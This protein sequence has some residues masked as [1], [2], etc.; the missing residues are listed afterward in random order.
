V[1]SKPLL[2][3]HRGCRVSSLTR[4]NSDLPVENSLAAFEYALSQG[5]DGFEFDV[6]QTHDSRNVIW[7]DDYW[8]GLPIASTDYPSLCGPNG[9]LLSTLDD[10]LQQ[11]GHRAFLDIELKVRGVEISVVEALRAVPPQRGYMLSSFLPD[12]LIRLHNIDSSLPFGYICERDYALA[13]WRNI[14]IQTILPRYDLVRKELIEEAHQRG[15]QVSTWTVNSE[16]QMLQF[17]EWGIDGL[18]SDDPA[19]L[20]RTFHNE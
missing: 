2:L 12:T 15:R 7:H 10:V 5:C 14:P 16:N 6:R 1:K 17:A 18:I 9:E 13:I 4:H 11:F 20:Y 3:G 19:L 8:N